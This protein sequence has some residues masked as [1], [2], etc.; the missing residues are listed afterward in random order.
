[1][2]L[3]CTGWLFRKKVKKG[4]IPKSSIDIQLELLKDPTYVYD[5]VPLTK[6]EKETGG[7]RRTPDFE[8]VRLEILLK[9]CLEL[10]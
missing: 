3:A 2:I 8:N 10:R 1:M 6:K 7:G 9:I 5:G 4:L